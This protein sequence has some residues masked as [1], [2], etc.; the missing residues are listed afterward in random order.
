VAELVIAVP[1]LMLL[2]LL[3]VQFAIWEH[4]E[5]IAHATA[6]EA[7]PPAASSGQRRSSARSA[8]ACSPARRSPSP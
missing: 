1:L 6:E 4:A 8:A 2:I 5:N 7:P 3:I